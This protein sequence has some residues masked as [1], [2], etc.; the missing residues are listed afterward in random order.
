MEVIL[1]ERVG[2]LGGTGD[3]VKVKN[4]FGRNFL[5]PQK[6]ALRATAENKKIFEARRAE[7]EAKNAAARAEAEARAKKL[8]GLSLTLSRQA[9][10]EGKLFGSVTVRDIAEALREQGHD[11]P[12]S[13]IIISGSIKSTGSYSVKAE[14]HPEVTVTISVNV[15][16]SESAEPD[17]Q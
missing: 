6:K 12:R 10:E 17:S 2:R 5:L 14:L 11:V 4:G 9:S 13:Q 1:L 7:I 16:K 15:V 8:E 3:I